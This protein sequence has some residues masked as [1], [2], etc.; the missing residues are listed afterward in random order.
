MAT[1][2]AFT[3]TQKEAIFKSAKINKNKLASALGLRQRF[4]LEAAT[5]AGIHW[6]FNLM[7]P[8][9]NRARAGQNC[10]EHDRTR[11]F[12]AECDDGYCSRSAELQ[13]I[14]RGML[15]WGSMKTP[16][17]VLLPVRWVHLV[18]NGKLAP[19]TR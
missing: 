16:R 15:P 5:G 4:R 10:Y 8:L 17:R 18:R 9:R 11:V 2:S 6:L 1:A 14:P 13:S 7:V 12:R 19:A 3:M